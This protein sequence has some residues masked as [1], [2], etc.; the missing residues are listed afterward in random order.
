MKAVHCSWKDMYARRQALNGGGRGSQERY[1]Q[2]LGCVS[3]SAIEEWKAV[4][5]LIDALEGKVRI[6]GD[7]PNFMP[8]HALCLTRSIRKKYGPAKDKDGDLLWDDDVTNE[9]VEWVEKCDENEWTVE[10]FKAEL[11]R[12]SKKTRRPG[13]GRKKKADP[14]QPGAPILAD[15]QRFRIDQADC[16]QWFASLPAD[17]IDLVFGSPPYQQARLYL[18]DGEDPGIARDPDE[19]V[20]WMVQ[21]YKAALRCCTGLV[22]FVVEGQTTDYRWSATPALL[23]AALHE[24]GIHLRKPAVYHRVGIPGSGGRDWLRNDY[25]F[26]VCATRGGALPWADNVAMGQPPK[27]KP[28]GDP[29]HRKKDGSRVNR[30]DD[31]DDYASTA[32]RA[33]QGPHRARQRSG[34]AYKPPEIAN[35]GNVITCKVGGK[36][37]GDDLCHQNE[38]PFPEH[39][40]E[41]FVKSF[42]PPDGVVCDPFSGSGTVAKMALT[43]S[44]RFAGCDVRASQT[45]LTSLRVAA[46]LAA[47]RP[48]P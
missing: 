18:E 1:R 7:Y 46:E 20:D 5:D 6:S 43:Y 11:L 4:S 31:G 27:Y 13:G 8:Q 17:S 38:A 39:L 32:E 26:I 28:G 40:A 14:A 10:E 42:C 33:D 2:M 41:F 16:L 44:R 29:S 47:G 22:A 34:G 37:M 24:S 19:W 15:G 9:A 48:P 25:E 35:P 12:A 36:N 23:M 3:K 21:V 45:E 30:K